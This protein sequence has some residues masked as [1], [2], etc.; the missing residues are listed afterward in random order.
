MVVS[1]TTNRLTDRPDVLFDR[2]LKRLEVRQEREDVGGDDFDE[3]L[4]HH[5]AV[6]EDALVA[7]QRMDDAH[8]LVAEA[9]LIDAMGEVEGDLVEQWADMDVA[10]GEVDAP[11]AGDVKVARHLVQRERSVDAARVER[12]VRL[13]GALGQ[14]VG[15]ILVPSVHD[16]FEDEPLRT[17]NVV[18]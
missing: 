1:K 11:A 16:V 14:V 3:V 10:A 2:I 4:R 7:L 13:H 15:G 6:G 5:G 18:N 9:E 17:R 12:L 8:R